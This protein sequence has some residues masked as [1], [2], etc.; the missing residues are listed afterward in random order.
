MHTMMHTCIDKYLFC[1]IVRVCI[2]TAAPHKFPEALTAAGVPYVLPEK[3]SQIFDL[4]T[5]FQFYEPFFIVII[6]KS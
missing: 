2:A 1:S 4:P 3:I 6:P 5:R